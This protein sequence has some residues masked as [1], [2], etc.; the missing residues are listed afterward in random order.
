MELGNKIF[1]S[2]KNVLQQV[3]N[4]VFSESIK[5]KFSKTQ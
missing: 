2:Q 1:A 4:L 3:R 5:T